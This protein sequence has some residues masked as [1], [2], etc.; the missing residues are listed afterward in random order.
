MSTDIEPRTV[1]LENENLLYTGWYL[2]DRVL[3]IEEA[4]CKAVKKDGYIPKAYV[5]DASDKKQI[6][7][8]RN[9][10]RG[11]RYDPLTN[12]KSEVDGNEYE[13]EN[14]G[15]TLCLSDAP[16]NSWQRGKLSFC[17]CIIRKDDKAWQVGIASD[18][19]INLLKQSDCLRGEVQ[20]EIKFARNQG[21]LGMVRV[22]SESYNDAVKDKN[23]RKTLSK[24]KKAKLGYEHK[25]LTENNVWVGDVYKWFT[26]EEMY[27]EDN[28][29]NYY[30]RTTV[31]IPKFILGNEP[32]K[33]HIYLSVDRLENTLHV[34]EDPQWSSSIRDALLSTVSKKSKQ[35]WKYY[36]SS[37]FDNLRQSFPARAVGRKVISDELTQEIFDEYIEALRQGYESYYYSKISG[38]KHVYN[39][40]CGK[41]VANLI[42]YTFSEDKPTIDMNRLMKWMEESESKFIIEIDGK[43]YMSKALQKALDNQVY[44]RLRSVR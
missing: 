16:S 22:G 38:V 26:E 5:A 27:A 30:G 35:D 11:Y 40:F 31:C 24:T 29:R 4:E 37:I 23:I 25:A 28:D 2:Y 1:G 13:Y 39:S 21:K 18:L 12:T 8:G 34:N 15:F 42:G 7:T 19:L 17:M 41:D 14:T 32:E 43:T 33:F 36:S 44:S 10:A 20:G 3:I 9:W 6:S